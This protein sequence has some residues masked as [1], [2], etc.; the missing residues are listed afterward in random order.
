MF[1]KLKTW[2]GNTE[3]AQFL[4]E[5]FEG[6]N[7]RVERVEARFTE[8][9]DRLKAM[10]ASQAVKPAGLKPLQTQSAVPFPVADLV[11]LLAKQQTL[12]SKS[13]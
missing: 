5:E 1:E 2:L 8:L 9:E 12:P 3:L 11:D 7:A 10:V 13:A 6:V 4:H